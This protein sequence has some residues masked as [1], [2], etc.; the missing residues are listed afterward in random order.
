MKYTQKEINDAQLF[1]TKF[2]NKYTKGDK[3]L[4]Y[5][6]L[7]FNQDCLTNVEKTHLNILKN[8]FQKG[9]LFMS[10]IYKMKINGM[11]RK[12][13]FLSDN[14]TLQKGDIQF[15]DKSKEDILNQPF[16]N[17]TDLI[18]TLCIGDKVSEHPQRI[19]IR[20]VDF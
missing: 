18:Q 4:G 15:Y 10:K 14:D 5:E 3:K 7:L 17:N 8:Q 9:Q 16:L 6:S 13:K 12:F 2:S 19:Y 20:L 1:L 11:K